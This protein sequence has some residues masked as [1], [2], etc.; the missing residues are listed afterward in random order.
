MVSTTPRRWQPPTLDATKNWLYREAERG[1]S[2]VYWRGFLM[3]DRCRIENIDGKY[4]YRLLYPAHALGELM[5]KAYEQ[6]KVT[7]VQRKRGIADYDYIAIR[8]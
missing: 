1:N 6:G 7:L 4:F 2:L 5:W 3:C 8:R